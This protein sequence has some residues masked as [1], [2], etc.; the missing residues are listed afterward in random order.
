MIQPYMVKHIQNYCSCLILDDMIS[1]IYKFTLTDTDDFSCTSIQDASVD[2]IFYKN[3]HNHEQGIML[4]GPS[5][6][7]E[8]NYIVFK[9]GYN[10]IGIRF[11]PG[12]PLVLKH[13]ETK[14][15]YDCVLSLDQQ[16]DDHIHLTAQISNMF[17]QGCKL[18]VVRQILFRYLSKPKD[19]K[20]KLC[21]QMIDYMLEYTGEFR[22]AELTDAFGY[23]EYY[24]NKIFHAY[25]GY[26]VKAY[27]NLLRIH[28]ALN[29][30]EQESTENIMP[31]YSQLALDLGYSD[32]AHMTREFQK[33]LGISPHKFW[34]DGYKI[35]AK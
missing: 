10:Y 6:K 15:L 5:K 3:L 22:R 9:G 19:R 13:T 8:N 1:Q 12:C 20:A 7:L 28:R 21:S 24:M 26:S 14:E 33:Y 2:I 27:Y 25:T 16:E 34:K 23:T 18:E 11:K 35:T 17:D 4:V 32:Q 30:Y 31:R 29:Y